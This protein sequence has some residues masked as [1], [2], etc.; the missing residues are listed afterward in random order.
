MQLQIKRLAHGTFG[1]A[2]PGFDMVQRMN[3]VRPAFHR[4]GR[5]HVLAPATAQDQPRTCLLQI[6]RKPRQRMMQPPARGR[7]HPPVPWRFVIKHIDRDYGAARGGSPESGL[8]S[9]AQVAAEPDDD[10]RGHTLAIPGHFR[11]I[12][13]DFGPNLSG[14]QRHALDLR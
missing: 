5:K 9:Q 7:P 12:K 6:G 13:L 11:I 4:E 3:F 14:G 10:G 1:I 2:P 8:I